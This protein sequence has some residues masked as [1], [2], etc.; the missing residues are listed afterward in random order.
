MHHNKFHKLTS[1]FYALSKSIQVLYLDHNQIDTIESPKE[2]HP[3]H[4]HNFEELRTLT[5]R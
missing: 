5:L 4:Q 2:G 3:G 1:G